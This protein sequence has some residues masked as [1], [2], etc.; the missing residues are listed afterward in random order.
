MAAQK[1]TSVPPSREPGE[2]APEGQPGPKPWR[3][4]GLPKGEPPKRRPRWAT[5]GIWLIGYLILFGVLTVQ[6]R[7]SGPQLISYTDF[8][9]QVSGKNVSELFARGDS[10]ES[11]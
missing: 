7:L 3:T 5:L 4:E 1:P 10:I 9:T 11:I 8:K 2:P 6:D